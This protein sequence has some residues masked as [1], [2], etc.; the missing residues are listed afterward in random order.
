MMTNKL[1]KNVS[2]RGIL[3]FSFPTIITMLFLSLYT[4][5][6]GLLVARFINTNALSAINIVYP[7]N[8]LQ[9]AVA[10][11]LSMGC[12]AIISTKLGENKIKEAR[13]NFTFIFLISLLTG[14]VFTIIG[15]STLK[16]VVKLLGATELT[17]T[18]SLQYASMLLAV[19]PVF[20]LQTFLNFAFA[21]IG[22]PIIG[23][24]LILVSGFTNLFFDWLFM[25][26]LNMGMIGAGLAS[27]VGYGLSGLC[28]LLYFF[29]NRDG[30]R[31]RKPK[32]DKLVLWRTVSN[33]ASE[34]VS[35]L[36]NA[37][38]TLIF[39]LLILKYYGE[40]GV[41]AITIILYFQFLF[42]SLH[43]GYSNG[44]NPIVSFKY[45]NK[46]DKELK[47]IYKVSLIFIV[48]N[49][50]LTFILSILVMKQ[51][52][53][54]FTK[55]Q[56]NVYNIAMEGFI[57]FAISF[58]FCGIGI[59]A[60]SWFTAFSE[61][62]ASTIISVLRTFVFIVGAA[63]ILPNIFGK[64]GIWLIMP[65]AEALGVLVSVYFLKKKKKVYSY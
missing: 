39:N 27:G 3:K 5:V 37:I 28:A 36:A 9:L 42:S 49:S 38:T 11:M 16:P 20:F 1:S 33:G 4:I 45:G 17:Y 52:I 51:A 22:K 53:L 62:K 32:F 43:L 24:F 18:Y 12:N 41:A 31:F 47:K 46:K 8:A 14:V 34:M 58:I 30:F 60:S 50:L 10:I 13:E 6:D 54:F 56:N 19:A 23:L 21:A 48:I 44:I 64:K 61:G 35:N 40:D 59:F 7:L 29:F 65:V 26:V 55:T 57:L 2:T 15:L 63:L 25:A